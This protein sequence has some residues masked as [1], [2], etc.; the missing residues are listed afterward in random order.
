MKNSALR[1]LRSAL[2]AAVLSAGVFSEAA[3]CDDIFHCY[4]GREFGKVMRDMEKVATKRG[5]HVFGDG[6]RAQNRLRYSGYRREFSGDLDAVIPIRSR[7]TK[8]EKEDAEYAFFAQ[9]GVSK[10]TH[11][12]KIARH[13]MRLGAVWRFADHS[14]WHSG[15]WG[16]YGFLQA[17]A[18]RGHYGA[19]TGGDYS[20]KYGR[21]S[22]N[23]FVPLSGWR[24][25]GLGYD[26]RPLMSGEANFRLQFGNK[27]SANGWARYSESASADGK[28]YLSANAGLE[29]KAR[30]W[31]VFGGKA[32]VSGSSKDRYEMTAKL[33]I[34]MDAKRRWYRK[35]YQSDFERL[36]HRAVS[37]PRRILVKERKHPV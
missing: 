17:D 7:I 25:N 34:P 29:Y 4:A 36:A 9:A 37:K 3:A 21:A 35:Y 16:F 18:G 20:G 27:L 8:E 1:F 24:N 31:L 30:E 10:W 11:R 23:V 12:K 33:V 32:R 13:D 6:F 28:P 26:S 5:R 2:S 22:A 19:L 14:A 15:V